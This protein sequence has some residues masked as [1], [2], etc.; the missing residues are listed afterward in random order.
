V[1]VST[2]ESHAAFASAA[3]PDMLMDVLDVCVSDVSKSGSVPPLEA[4]R[5]SFWWVISQ[6]SL[7]EDTCMTGGLHGNDDNAEERYWTRVVR[8]DVMQW[9]LH[10]IE[11]LL[12]GA[13]F[14]YRYNQS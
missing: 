12:C 6:V 9:Y 8:R 1:R 3:R 14:H 4:R 7:L 13:S 11:S 2:W 5:R 10:G